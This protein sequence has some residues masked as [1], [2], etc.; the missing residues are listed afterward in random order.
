MPQ[1]QVFQFKLCSLNV[2]VRLNSFASTVANQTFP[3]T[4]EQQ[5][6]PDSFIA[7]GYAAHRG[8]A[9]ERNRYCGFL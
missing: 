9:N 4:D 5:E 3:L 6:K 7:L 2:V 8:K 1:L